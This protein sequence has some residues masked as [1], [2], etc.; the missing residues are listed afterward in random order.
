MK[1]TLLFCTALAAAA[2]LFA[3]GEAQ[4]ASPASVRAA[5]AAASVW[6][7]TAV[8][9]TRLELG[10][11]RVAALERVHG[12]FWRAEIIGADGLSF[13]IFLAPDGTPL[14]AMSLSPQF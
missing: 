10:S 12:L 5:A 2:G 4:A 13:H 8:L 14:P 11:Y 7:D 3:L 6:I 9:T 1:R